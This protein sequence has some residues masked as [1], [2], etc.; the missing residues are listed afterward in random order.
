MRKLSLVA[1]AVAM[2]AS[3]SLP[4]QAFAKDG[5]YTATSAGRNGGIDVEVTIKSDKIASVKVLDWSET[6][7]VADAT[8]TELVS[9]IVKYQSTDVD[10]ISG[11]TLSSFAIKD[12]VVQCIEQAGLDPALFEKEIPKPPMLTDTQTLNSDVIVV[13]GGGAGLSAAVAAAE[14]GKRVIVI[15]KNHFLGGNTSVC[16]G[17]FNVANVGQDQIEM[18]KGQHDIV[19]EILAVKPKNKLH[20]EL[21]AKTKQ[22]YEAYVKSGS[23]KLFDS[24]ELHALQSWK[25]GDYKADLQLVYTLT[26]NV[27]KMV[28]KLEDMGFVWREKATQFVGALWP[29]S[30]RALNYKSGVGYVNTFVKYIKDKNLPVTFYLDTAASDLIVKDG[31]VVGVKAKNKNGRSY[32]FNANGGVVLATGGFGANVEMRNHYDELWGKKLGKAT[33]TTNLRSATGDG[34]KMAQQA[35]ARL[36]QMGWIQLFPA[37]DPA[38]GATSFKVGENSCIYV[39]RDGKRYVNESER[40]DVLAKANLAQK[41]GVFFVISSAKRAMIDADGRNA[42]GVKIEDIL[43][44]GKTFKAD[45][46]EELAKKAGINPTNL[47]KTVE[48]W[49]EFCKKGTGDEMGRPTCMDDHRLDEGGP[50]YAT[51]MKPSVHHTMGGVAITP[52]AEV[53]DN[54]GKI[55]KGLFAAGEV[56]GGIHGTNRVGCNAVPDALVFGRIAGTSAA[57]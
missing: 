55:I 50:Y 41:D 5:V 26:Q 30:N 34:I 9:N 12:A 37:A 14:A 45:T 42:F 17:C 40:R 43:K 23:T 21:I 51:L 19:K 22:Q 2:A 29:R 32:V 47:V 36:T 20:E 8:R 16:G 3:I 52:K 38:T 54:N 7:P 31:A 56:T 28:T 18:T 27:G 10:S 49:N 1:V 24:P 33:P 48:K 46:I 4:M 35:N 44:S 13:G 53:L 15:E 11:A 25:S 39:N 57:K 6:T